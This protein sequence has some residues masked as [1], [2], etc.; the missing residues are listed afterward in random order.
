MLDELADDTP[1]EIAG[2][3]ETDADRSAVLARAEDAGV[4]ADELAARVHQRAAGI[5]AVDR[6]V[7]LDEIL[8]SEKPRFL[9]PSALMMP[10]DTLWLN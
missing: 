5:A 10:S 1:P 6:G 4:D 8:V 2:N 9:R 3:G 7:G